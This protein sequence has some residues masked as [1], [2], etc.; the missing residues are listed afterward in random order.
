MLNKLLLN[1]M[2]DGKQPRV[3]LCN[4]AGG[5]T[6]RNDLYQ[7]YKAN[8]PEAP[9]D[10][11]PQFDLIYEAAEAYGIVQVKAPGYEADDVIATLSQ[12]ALAQGLSVDI[13]SGD[14]DLMQLI[15]NS[16]SDSVG[17]INMIDPM[18]MSRMT[19]DTVIEKWGVPSHQLGDLLALAG[20]TADN[21]PGVPGIGPKIAAQLLQEYTTLEEVLSRS[22]EIKQVKRRENLQKYADQA[23]LSQALVEL[24]T[25]VPQECFEVTP[26]EVAT[27]E[28]H[29]IKMERMDPD[30][31]LEFYDSMGFYTIKKRLLERLDRQEQLIYQRDKY[32]QKPKPKPRS[33][34]QT[35]SYSGRK[36]KKVDPPKPED[37]EGVPF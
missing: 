7:E 17:R 4:D 19:H 6:F 2:L 11:L 3:I 20:D 27:K 5:G 30:R 28:L 18:T 8:R 29:E 13:L 10:L 12:Q 33:T 14:K 25:D 34:S 1:S 26:K 21:I 32:R 9:I 31:I 37:Y 22:D 23:R 24:V 16:T 35:R 15:T 36:G